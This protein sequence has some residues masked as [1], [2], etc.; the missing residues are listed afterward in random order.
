M[1]LA[2]KMIY[3]LWILIKD[4]KNVLT[5]VS[6]VVSISSTAYYFHFV[7]MKNKDLKIQ[8]QWE[9]ILLLEVNVSNLSE[10]IKKLKDDF[11]NQSFENNQT[12]NNINSIK[13]IQRIEEIKHNEINS[14]IGH[15]TINV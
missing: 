15:H 6:L 3:D 8:S 2:L 13:E 14:S 4:Y 1:Q 10:S 9:E 7:P 12:L 11:K 5:V